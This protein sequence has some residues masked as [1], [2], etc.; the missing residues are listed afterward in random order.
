MTFR[1]VEAAVP[2]SVPRFSNRQQ[3]SH[4]LSIQMSDSGHKL[5]EIRPP[6]NKQRPASLPADLTPVVEEPE[7]PRIDTA[8]T[9]QS[10]TTQPQEHSQAVE[11]VTAFLVE[12]GYSRFLAEEAVRKNGPDITACVNWLEQEQF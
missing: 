9:Q 12:M 11:E 10:D 2:Q 4:S 1:D 3:K 5:G 6:Q 7:P 8:N